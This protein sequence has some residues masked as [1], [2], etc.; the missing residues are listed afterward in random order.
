MLYEEFRKKIVD[1]QS[2]WQSFKVEF[3]DRDGFK[4]FADQLYDEVNEWTEVCITG[5]FSERIRKELERIIRL[6]GRKVRLICPEF[7]VDFKRDRKNLEALRKLASAGAQIKVCNRL[8]ARFFVAYG[9]SQKGIKGF[10]VIGSF[11]FN[12]ECIGLERYDAGIRTSNPDLVQSAVNLFNQ[13]WNEP[14]S[15]P[16]IERYP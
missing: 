8:H 6:Q 1:L 16:L 10:L 13:I 3:I 11:D 14:E 7:S 9:P 12:T 5:Y 15:L 4:R 2:D